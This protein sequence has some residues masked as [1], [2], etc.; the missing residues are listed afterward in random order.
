VEIEPRRGLATEE[1]TRTGIN[2]GG[3]FMAEQAALKVDTLITNGITITM[4]ANRTIYDTGYVAIANGKIVAT[5]SA[6]AC[7]Y[8]AAETIDASGMVV[9]PGLINGHTHLDQAVYRG[10]F[11]DHPAMNRDTFLRMCM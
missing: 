10:C 11:N 9:L 6:A 4:D 7:P 2:G 8:E 1:S 5:G 3:D